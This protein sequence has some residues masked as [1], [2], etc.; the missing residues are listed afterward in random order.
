[1]LIEVVLHAGLDDGCQG[2]CKGSIVKR[3]NYGFYMEDTRDAKVMAFTEAI[4]VKNLFRDLMGRQVD[5]FLS[6]KGKKLKKVEAIIDSEKQFCLTYNL[7]KEE[8]TFEFYYDG[9]WNE[10]GMPQHV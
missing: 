5:C 1:M 6:R 9:S 8:I 2:R 7:K 4:R 10:H 3:T